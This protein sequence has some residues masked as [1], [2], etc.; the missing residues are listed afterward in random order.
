MLKSVCKGLFNDLQGDE[1]K[2][3]DN[4]VA[5]LGQVTDGLDESLDRRCNDFLSEVA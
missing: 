5:K 1:A 4:I 2:V 3:N